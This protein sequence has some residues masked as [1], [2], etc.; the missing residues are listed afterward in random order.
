[1]I[2]I[3]PHGANYIMSNDD[4]WAEINIRTLYQQLR[5]YNERMS[6]MSQGSDNS[7]VV[8]SAPALNRSGTGSL[9]GT[10]KP[11]EHG[12][13]FKSCSP[14]SPAIGFNSSDPH[15]NYVNSFPVT[16]VSYGILTLAP[17]FFGGPPDLAILGPN[18]GSNL[19]VQIPF[20]GTV[21]SAV[22]A[23]N[24]GVP[25]IAFHGRTGSHTAW[26]FRPVPRYP[27]LYAKYAVNIIATLTQSKK[28][29][30][31]TGVWLNVNFPSVEPGKCNENN[32][33]YVLSRIYPAIPVLDPPD[34]TTCGSNRLPLERT[35]VDTDGCYVSISVGN[36]NKLDANRDAQEAVLNRLSKILSCL[37]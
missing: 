16:A 21:G 34:V 9:N 8:L 5:S 25:A 6:L 23:T 14:G 11:V 13:E 18:V 30:L 32:A 19:D 27:R 3:A 4:G 2:P 29:Y 15:L 17:K 26:N 31:P 1:M 10:A 12:C 37:P 36:K 35:V 7:M 24:L 22:A 28:P 20:S 33:K